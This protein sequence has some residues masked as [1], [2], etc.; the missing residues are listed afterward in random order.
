M[1]ARYTKAIRKFDRKDPSAM[2]RLTCFFLVLLLLLSL[3]ACGRTP[4]GDPPQVSAGQA[5]PETPEEPEVPEPEPYAIS[6]PTV[7][8]EG[9]V[10]DGVTYVPWDGIVEHLFFHPVVAY[11]EL[12]FDGDAQAN[13]IDDYMV[14]VDEYDKILQSVYDKGYILVDINDV[15]SETT[16][17][18]GQPKMVRNTLY[19]PEGK[20]PLILSFDD[21]NYYPYMLTN[22]FTYKLIIGDDGKIWSWGL[23]PAGSEVTS[24]DLDAIPILDKFVEEHP[25]F[26]P[27]GAKGCLSLTGYEGILGYRT[28]TTTQGWTAEQEA[29]RQKEIEA[30]KPVIAELKRTG[31]TFGSHTWGHIRLGSK[32]LEEVQADTQRWADEVASLV[33]PTTILF[34]PHGERPDGNDWQKT[35]PVFQYLQSQGFRVFCSVG[36]ESFSYIKKDICAVI[37][38]RLHPDG[39]TLRYSRQRYLQF[40]DAKDIMDVD[41]RPQR[42]IKWD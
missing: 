28:Q 32:S 15:W 41:V 37:C 42:E 36:I 11:P 6:D 13:G 33:G 34:Y 7:M 23:D 40:Y 5:E 25:D 12:A 10:R 8:P 4:S 19:L 31:W 22:G 39:T 21:T 29:N 17:E 38:D 26:S 16:G 3:S 24:R 35:G 2:R 9:G 1:A 27:F 20:K 18:D 14:T 30:V